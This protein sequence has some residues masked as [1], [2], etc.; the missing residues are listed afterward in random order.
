MN[1]LPF[2]RLLITIKICCLLC[3]HSAFAQSQ[4]LT[5]EQ[6]DT[7]VIRFLNQATFGATPESFTS[8]R[9][10]IANDGSNRLAIYD[11]WINDQIAQTPSNMDTFC[12]S[13]I[14]GITSDIQRAAIRDVPD[15][16][17]TTFTSAKDQLRQRVA[18]ALSQILVIST[19]QVAVR[20]AYRGVF[21]YWD[22]LSNHAFGE[23][24]NLLYDVSI[25]PVMGV[26]LSHISN[27]KAVPGTGIYPDENYARE[28]MQLF[29][30]G[31][32]QRRLDGSVITDDNGNPIPTYDNSVI[33]GMARVFTGLSFSR[34]FDSNGESIENTSFNRSV[35]PPFNR[36][37][38]QWLA[39]MK[40]FTSQHDY[41]EK[42]LFTDKGVTL[43]LPA[44]TEKTALAALEEIQTV[45]N[46][47]AAHSSTAPY[48]SRILIQRLVT[49]NPSPQYIERVATQFANNGDMTATI[50][51]ILLDPE[52]RDPNNVNSD[53]FGK[54]KE[55]VLMLT[56]LF[57]LLEAQSG[58]YLDQREFGINAAN[59]DNFEQDATLLRIGLLSNTGQQIMGAPSVFNFYSPNFS[60]AGLLADEG[61]VAPEQ[62][63]QTDNQLISVF[64]Y[65]H[66]LTNNSLSRSF[67]VNEQNSFLL[68]FT[69]D[70]HKT[71]WNQQLLES[72][73]NSTEGD[74]IIKA[75]ALIDFLDFYL[76]AGFLHAERATSV[77]RSAIVKNVSES[78]EAAR[79]KAVLNGVINAPETQIQR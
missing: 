53:R 28:V 50:K 45:T 72:I 31:L 43:T 27:P 12:N 25:H 71:G 16:Y 55:P 17:W 34:W 39:P 47:L 32:V 26:W 46:A 40:I 41:D 11:Q 7:D 14:T 10:Q 79:Y 78:T 19:Q 38:N 52:A 37:Q 18:F 57:R 49:S 23:Y 42:V 48:I 56:N 73:W 65:Y 68:P 33:E 20:S 36:G 29:S 35:R 2:S 60:P 4:S 24:K 44:A 70:N 5:S 15:C 75:E 64:N 21:T 6:V 51:A 62:Q 76:N 74:N 8:L 9:S 3:I 13:A 22:T 61:I 67:P 69:V 54:V 63:L 58:I 77:T 59:F 66:R 1:F 30:M